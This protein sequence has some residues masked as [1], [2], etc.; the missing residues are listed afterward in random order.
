MQG[1]AEV[2]QGAENDAPHYRRRVEPRR[3]D[4]WYR[5]RVRARRARTLPP[6]ETQRHERTA[7]VEWP[8][9]AAA[10]SGYPDILHEDYDGMTCQ[11]EALLPDPPRPA[12]PSRATIVF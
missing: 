4:P 12:D 10:V 5:E 7:M 8:S 6:R 1:S 3:R 11:R 2:C 9:Y